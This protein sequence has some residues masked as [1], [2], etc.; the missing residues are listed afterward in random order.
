[1]PWPSTALPSHKDIHLSCGLQDPTRPLVEPMLARS[2]DSWMGALAHAA[3]MMK[4]ALGIHA[5]IFIPALENFTSL[6]QSWSERLA[7]GY[8]VD[9]DSTAA[10]IAIKGAHTSCL[11]SPNK[12]HF[13]VSWVRLRVGPIFCSFLLAL[14][15]RLNKRKG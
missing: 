5:S 14:Q 6:G 15:S 1:M 12:A 4:A 7:D 11:P 2:N 13:Q 8:N 9:N 3:G 10:S